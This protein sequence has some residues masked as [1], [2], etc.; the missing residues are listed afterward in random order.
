V[1]SA[2][3]KGAPEE[4]VGMIQSPGPRALRLRRGRE[5][6]AGF[7]PVELASWLCVRYWMPHPDV[8]VFVAAFIAFQIHEH[9]L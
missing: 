8:R 1:A 2:E 7:P 9:G 4:L 5:R 3:G 6:A